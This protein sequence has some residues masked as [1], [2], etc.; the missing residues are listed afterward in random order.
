MSKMLKLLEFV[1]KSDTKLKI[2]GENTDAIKV[3]M[4]LLKQHFPKL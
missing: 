4:R 2:K 1:E 3:W